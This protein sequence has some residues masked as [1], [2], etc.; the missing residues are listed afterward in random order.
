M[1]D[2]IMLEHWIL[3]FGA[4][5][6]MSPLKTLFQNYEPLD[7]QKLI[8]MGD[9]SC[10]KTINI[11][12]IWIQLS[13]IQPFVIIKVLYVLGLIKNLI[14]V[15]Q[16]TNTNN[17]K[18]TFKHENCVTITTSPTNHKYVYTTPK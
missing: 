7:S 8:Y 13:I 3:D 5:Q 1:Q 9:N 4:S 14:L 6:R 12:S 18:I 11:S 10:H 16:I 2:S 17:T 15:S